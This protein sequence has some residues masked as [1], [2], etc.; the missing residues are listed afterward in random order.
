MSDL[1]YSLFDEPEFSP[2]EKKPSTELT[3][4]ARGGET[5][6]KDQ[7][8]FNRLTA[9]IE[10]L[11]REIEQQRTLLN[12]LLEEYGKRFRPVQRDYAQKQLQLAHFISASADRYRYG[13]RQI[14]DVRAVIL[15]L[16]DQA[17]AL[18]EP[19]EKTITMYDQWS[20]STYEEEIEE[21]MQD[22]KEMFTEQMREVFG[23]DVD[24]SDLDDSPEGFARFMSEFESNWQNVE[25][26]QEK[27]K[28]RK[29]TA[30]QIE[31]EL[32]EQKEAEVRKK[33]VRSIYLSL[34]KVLHPDAI[35]DPDERMNREEFMKEVTAAYKQ[36]DLSTLLKLEL[37]WVSTDEGGLK[38]LPDVKLRVYIQ[39]LKEQ[40]SELEHVKEELMYDPRY[41]H[42]Q[43]FASHGKKRAFSVI[44]TQTEE[45]Q[46]AVDDLE[47][48]L[49]T[50][51]ESTPKAAIMAMVHDYVADLKARN[52]FENVFASLVQGFY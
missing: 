50:W 31:K 5:L 46:R 34:A 35:A 52:E 42:V 18:Y 45:L 10:N 22:V 28:P 29:K 24:L 36:N 23:V 41:V 38:E 25:P 15:D 32:R 19:D 33:T 51:S 20:E 26:P 16:C 1:N 12:D 14:E 47:E 48:L 11:H 37:E 9:R 4:R 7:K 6:S 49:S 21:Q 27:R 30:K 44:T 8:T 17:F 3:I 40:I 2:R 39:S 43:A 13:K